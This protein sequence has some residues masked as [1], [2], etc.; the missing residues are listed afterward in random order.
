MEQKAL[1]PTKEIHLP[2][3]A[4][5]EFEAKHS[6]TL[7]NTVKVYGQSPNEAAA[8]AVRVAM[9]AQDELDAMR[10]IVRQMKERE[11]ANG[12]R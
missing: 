5:L 4:V 7:T 6:A 2:E 8:E 12:Q 9:F 3:G 10:E 11:A 1:K